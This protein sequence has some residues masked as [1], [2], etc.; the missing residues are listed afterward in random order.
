MN[1][2]ER[3]STSLPPRRISEAQSGL[4]E[5]HGNLTYPASMCQFLVDPPTSSSASDEVDAHPSESPR[6]KARQIRRGESSRNIAP[7]GPVCRRCLGLD[8]PDSRDRLRGCKL[9][10][11]TTDDVA[12]HQIPQLFPRDLFLPRKFAAYQFARNPERCTSPIRVRL[13]PPEPR[14]RRTDRSRGGEYFAVGLEHDER[15]ILV[16]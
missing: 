11:E 7:R 8:L 4:T 3:F 10:M 14:I 15:R 12:G 1:V 16:T 6:H 5:I 13:S 9:R 2:I